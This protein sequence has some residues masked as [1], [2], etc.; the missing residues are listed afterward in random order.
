MNYL[1]ILLCHWPQK[2]HDIAS[3]LW[4]YGCTAVWLRIFQGERGGELTAFS[5]WACLLLIMYSCIF[6]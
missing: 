4:L 1:L 3:A 6:F 2:S 5:S